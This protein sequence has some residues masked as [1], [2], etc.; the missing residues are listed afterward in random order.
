MP[1]EVS[2]IRTLGIDALTDAS[3]PCSNRIHAVM[4]LRYRE[5]SS[6]VTDY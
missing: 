5:Y 3:V 6:L 2:H 4:K 1:V